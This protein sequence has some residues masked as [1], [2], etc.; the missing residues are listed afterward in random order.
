MG[1]AFLVLNNYIYNGKAFKHSFVIKKDLENNKGLA[2]M[3]ALYDH[4]FYTDSLEYDE[5]FSI[6][7]WLRVQR[8]FAIFVL[9]PTDYLDQNPKKCSNPKT[10]Q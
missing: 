8:E 1:V 6:E 3:D 2:I 7:K 4:I 10:S 9:K 5:K